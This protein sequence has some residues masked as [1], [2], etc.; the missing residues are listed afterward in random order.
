MGFSMTFQSETE[1]VNKKIFDF[2]FKCTH[3]TRPEYF[4]RNGK[5]VFSNMILLMLNSMKQSLQLELNS[6]FDNILKNETPAAKQAFSKNR[7]KISSE[8]FIDLNDTLIDVIYEQNNEYK[9][10]NG[11]R[12]SAIDGTTIELPNTELLR[13]KFAFAKNQIGE[14]ARTKGA[15]IFDVVNKI[16]LKSKIDRYDKGE[17]EMALSMIKELK[18]T[19]TKK[20]LIL[21]V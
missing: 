11:F 8:A 6:F 3:R 12:L 19:G 17:R 21:F 2:M 14:T 18:G 4:S 15:C 5:L 9:L 20:D 1:T 13:N 10:W 7:Q 16:V